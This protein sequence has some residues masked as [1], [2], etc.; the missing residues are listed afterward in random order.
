[1]AVALF[2]WLG[3]RD[4]SAMQADRRNEPGP[5]LSA[6]KAGRFPKLHVLVERAPPRPGPKEKKD[7]PGRNYRTW[8]KW[9]KELVAGDCRIQ[10]HRTDLDG[11]KEITNHEAIY[12]EATKAVSETLERAPADEPVFLLTPGTPAMHAVMLLIGKTRQPEIRLVVT[13]EHSPRFSDANVPFEISAAYTPRLD[14]RQSE[15]LSML[16]AGSQPV[17]PSFDKIIGGSPELTE[18]KALASRYAATDVPV[19]IEGESGT[20]KELF[21]RAIHNASKRSGK[22]LKVI[23]CG[24]LPPSLIESELFGHKRGAF[25]GADR[26]RKGAFES[27][28]GSTVFLD[29]IGEC[30][31]E[32]QTRLLRVLQEGEVQRIGE[33]TYKKID[34]RIIAATNR[35]LADMVAAGDFR[36]D[37]YW[38]LAVGVLEL[39]ALRERRRDIPHL[40]EYQ[41]EQTNQKLAGGGASDPKKLSPA[42]RKLLEAHTWLGNFREL[43]NVLARAWI[44]ADDNTIGKAAIERAMTRRGIASADEQLLGRPLGNGFKIEEV[45]AELIRDYLLRA[46]RESG[47]NKTR[48]AELLGLGNPTTLT[49]WMKKYKIE[50]RG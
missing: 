12:R 32:V 17:D 28:S 8:E 5:I 10:V 50:Y 45:S 40:L 43:Q 13:S 14:S 1:M 19:L 27:A 49:N 25:T 21:A 23:D 16:T 42:A 48:A 4:I 37:L 20:G 6:V 15:A 33:A 22:D 31:P 30:P 47:G 2:S 7:N 18:A 34:I 44:F 9:A 3:S 38:R 29:E 35:R 39:P 36:N 46:L 24:A 11:E 41:L 26:D